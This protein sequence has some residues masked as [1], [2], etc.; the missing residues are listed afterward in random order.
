MQ[1]IPTLPIMSIFVILNVDAWYWSSWVDL[2]GLFFRTDL[3]SKR[4]SCLNIAV[5]LK[6]LQDLYL[7]SV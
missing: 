1:L 4:P 6:K 7:S 2:N 5:V 3:L